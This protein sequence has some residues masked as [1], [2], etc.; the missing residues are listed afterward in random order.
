MR[1]RGRDEWFVIG[2]KA[3]GKKKQNKTKAK[4]RKR[5]E[6]KR[7]EKERKKECWAWIQMRKDERVRSVNGVIGL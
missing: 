3:Q 7:K 2:F 1:K 4:E 5:K 6:K